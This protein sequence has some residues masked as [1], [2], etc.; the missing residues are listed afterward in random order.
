MKTQRLVAAGGVVFRELDSHFEV[1]LISRGNRWF[2]PRGVVES[3]ETTKIAALREVR[4]ETG[5][6]CEIVK[7]IGNFSFDFFR[8]RRYSKTIHFY[9][10]KYAGGSVHNHGAEVDKVKWFSI[11]EAFSL[12]KYDDEKKI[13]KKAE[14]MLLTMHSVV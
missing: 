13:L 11:S 10:L 5:L 6:D 12:L 14:A 4:E 9:L 1:A 8:G 3:D 2:L 7:K